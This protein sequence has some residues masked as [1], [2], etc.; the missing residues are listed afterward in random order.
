M[1]CF[2]DANVLFSG[3]NQASQ[4]HRLL[5]YAAVHHQLI[6]SEYA[7][8]EAIRNIRVKCETWENGFNLIMREMTVVPSIDQPLNVVI[9]PKDRPILAAAIVQECQRL[10]TG[11]KKD[12]GHLFRKEIEGVTILTPL[13]WTEEITSH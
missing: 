11:D 4:M 13:M 8:E 5:N 7:K 1:R 10:I 12:F 6:T 2:L 3:S 9:A